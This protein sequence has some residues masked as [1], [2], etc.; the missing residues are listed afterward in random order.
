MWRGVPVALYGPGHLS[1]SLHLCPYTLL[2]NY[3][4]CLISIKIKLHLSLCWWACH[5]TE[6]SRW[7]AV[8]MKPLGLLKIVR[9]LLD[10]SPF[11]L[12]VARCKTWG[13]V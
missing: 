13:H 7:L 6:G 9:F 10:C 2:C 5:N 8:T 3:F 1:A 12:A 4:F 11:L